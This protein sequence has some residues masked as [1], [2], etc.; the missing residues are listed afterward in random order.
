[1]HLNFYQI[2]VIPLL[3][4]V[5]LLCMCVIVHCL[6]QLTSYSVIIEYRYFIR[7]LFEIYLR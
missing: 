7:F 5:L 4:L 2:L 3:P 1:M 6:L